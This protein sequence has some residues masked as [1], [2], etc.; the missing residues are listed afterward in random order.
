[1]KIILTICVLFLFVGCTPSVKDNTQELFDSIDSLSVSYEN[2]IAVK[3]EQL[4]QMKQFA[5]NSFEH[6]YLRGQ[7]DAFEGKH[8]LREYRIAEFKKKYFQEAQ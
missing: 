1:V 4:T 7:V 8:G 2:L 3:D 6:G 5:I